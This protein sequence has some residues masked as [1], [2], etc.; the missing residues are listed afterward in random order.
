MP[1]ILIVEDK[2]NPRKVLSILLKKQGFAV[3]EACNGSI[4]M[5]EL[6]KRFF[7]LVI[8]D[9]KM[10]P[11]DGM[12]VLQETKKKFPNTQVILLTAFGSIENSVQAMKLGAFDYVTKPVDSGRF[13]MLVQKALQKKMQPKINAGLRPA[14]KHAFDSIIGQSDSLNKVLWMVSQVAGTESTILISGESGTGK[15][16]VAKAIHAKS[17]RADQPMISVNCGALT[18]S[19]LESELFG[20]VKGAFTGAVKD[21][22]GLFEEAKGSTLF[23][24][25]IGE[26]SMTTQVKLLRVLQEGE[27]RRLGE[28]RSIG[29]DVRVIAATN[30]DLEKEVREGRFREDL[31]YRLNVIPIH[32]PPLRERKEDIP[33]LGKYFLK[34]YSQKLLKPTPELSERALQRLGEW[35]WPGNVR[36]LENVIERTLAINY[37]SKLEPKHFLFSSSK[38]LSKKSSAPFW[39]GKTLADIEKLSILETLQI[40]KGNQKMA[41]EKLGIST[42]TLWRKLK[43]YGLE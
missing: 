9:L 19:L 37:A 17:I 8:T 31:Y 43:S 21:R 32:I 33:L 25:E 12:Q 13:L 29:V 26:I 4:A 38:S 34:K 24:D 1:E 5:E 35:D 42:T 36:E 27:I 23:L 20:H 39:E 41:A 10:E 15:E 7:D 30:K 22:K 14:H 6:N 3:S 18:E 2:A 16:L 11:V 40:Y 28:S